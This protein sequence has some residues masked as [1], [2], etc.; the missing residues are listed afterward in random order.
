M[1][2]VGHLL[3]ITADDC[4]LLL[5]ERTIGRVAWAS[6]QGMV[7]LPVTYV[8]TDGLIVFRVAE[9]TLPAELADGHEVAFEVDD[10]DEETGTGWSVLVRGRAR[11][12][13][14]RPTELP[15]PWA[16]G[17]RPVLVAI[18]P[19]AVTGRSVSAAWKPRG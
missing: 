9:D 19:T 12:H 11:A 10:I 18:E 5:A 16:P 17:E 6:S 15:Q 8:P 14:G 4:S 7:V 2:P 3:P 1:T 13:E